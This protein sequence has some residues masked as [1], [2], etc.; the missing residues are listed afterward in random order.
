MLRHN[1]GADHSAL[2]HNQQAWHA[3]ICGLSGG[4]GGER[5]HRCL[6][7]CPVEALSPETSVR[8]EIVVTGKSSRLIEKLEGGAHSHQQACPDLP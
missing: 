2:E 8:H 7:W 6:G 1:H 5:G 4:L 3:R